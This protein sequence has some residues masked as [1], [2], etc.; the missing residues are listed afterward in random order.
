MHKWAVPWDS[1]AAEEANRKALEEG[2]PVVGAAAG[3]G[4]EKR[5]KG[6]W[7]RIFGRKGGKARA[8]V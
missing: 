6:V 5:K 2:W 7:G 1:E 3:A 8:V 4:G